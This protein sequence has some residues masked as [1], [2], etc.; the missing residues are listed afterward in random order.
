MYR[1]NHFDPDEVS[2]LLRGLPWEQPGEVEVLWRD[3][4]AGFRV[5]RMG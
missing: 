5:V 4:N 1:M 3:E 2:E